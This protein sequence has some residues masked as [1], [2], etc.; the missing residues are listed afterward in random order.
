MRAMVHEIQQIYGATFKMRAKK[1]HVSLLGT[2]MIAELW[3]S[4]TQGV[5][6]QNA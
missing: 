3:N 5:T 2:E 1:P 4:E 6:S